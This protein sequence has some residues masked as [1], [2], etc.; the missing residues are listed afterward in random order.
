M[1]R[2]E[3]EQTAAQLKLR[4]FEVSAKTGK[5]VNELFEDILDILLQH[6]RKEDEFVES[7][8]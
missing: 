3:G 7:T 5:K 8:R 6:M 1:T 2:E 4:H